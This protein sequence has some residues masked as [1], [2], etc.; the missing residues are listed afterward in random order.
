MMEM[1]KVAGIGIVG[2]G[3]FGKFLRESWDIMPEVRVVA[4]CDEDISRQPEASGLATPRFFDD[5]SEMLQ[6][7]K[8]DIVC[9]ATPPSSHKKMALD[10]I[11][12]GK[13][14]LVEK[15]LATTAADARAIA[16]A[17]AKAGVVATVDFMLRF[18][19][20]VKVLRELIA[21]RVFGKLY[22]IDLRNYAQSEG[23]PEGHW[24]WDQSISGGILIEHGVHFFDLAAYLNQSPPIRVTGAAVERKP[25]MEDRVFATVTYENGVIGTFWHSFSL[26]LPLERT[27]IQFAFDLGEVNVSGWVPLDA[28][29]RGWTN[30]EGV[31]ML[32]RLFPGAMIQ[33][34]PREPEVCRS[35]GEEYT[36]CS[37]IQGSYALPKAKPEVYAD[38]LRDIMRD[39]VYA[40]NDPSCPLRVTAQDGIAAVELAEQAT[41]A[42]RRGTRNG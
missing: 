34:E 10:A 21:A 25:G 30:K 7:S 39:F 12:A 33:Q 36:V 11:A 29:F 32:K 3:G 16:E 38:C 31:R 6:D 37:S 17:A 26:P 41:A 35:A 18:D 14:A 22:R 4:V 5:Y 28:E 8:V 42:A 24:F 19:P 9:V 27:T 40:T 23:L 15:P 2:Y 20:L 13:H 1:Q